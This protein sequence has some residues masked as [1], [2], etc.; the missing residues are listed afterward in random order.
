VP[1]GLATW[2]ITPMKNGSIRV[3]CWTDGC[4]WHLDF[5]SD[6]PRKQLQDLIVY[7]VR[8]AHDI[9]ISRGNVRMEG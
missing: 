7:H 3:E 8:R 1:T 9:H 6:V 4:G 5:E 2:D